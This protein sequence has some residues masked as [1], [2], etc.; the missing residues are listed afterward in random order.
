[1]PINTQLLD[2]LFQTAGDAFF[3]AEANTG[4][5]IEANRRAEELTGY[6][7]SELI[8][9][10]QSQL[11]P[12]Q[13]VDQYRAIF[14]KHARGDLMLAASV[15]IVRKDGA[16]VPVEIQ[17]SAFEFEGRRLVFGIFRDVSDRDLL[18]RRLEQSE[19]RNRTIAEFAPISIV[20]HCN[21]R[22][23]FSNERAMRDL[24]ARTVGDLLGL[25]VLEFVHP[26][27][28]QRVN[29]RIRKMMIEKGS[30]PM[31]EERLQRLNGEYFNAEVHATA[32]EWDGMPS[33]MVAFQ[34]IDDRA[35]RRNYREA[36]LQLLQ[37]AFRHVD[38]EATLRELVRVHAERTNALAS[39]LTIKQ[40][41]GLIVRADHNAPDELIRLTEEAGVDRNASPSAFALVNETSIFVDCIEKLP[42]DER[43]RK[44]LSELSITSCWSY[45]VRDREGGSI[46]SLTV[47]LSDSRMPDD[48]ELEALEQAS[49]LTS[50]F[51]DRSDL[52]DE[53][54]RLSQVARQTRE[55]VILTDKDRKVVYVNQA[56]TDVTGYTLKDVAGKNLR[57][58]MHGPA[59]N[60]ATA[61]FMKQRLNEIRGFDCRIFNYRKTGEGFW[62]DLRIDPMFDRTGTHVGFI[63]LQTDV[64]EE[65]EA[66]ARLEK[67]LEEADEASKA[68]SEFLSIISHEIRTP[69]NSISGIVHL[70]SDRNRSE[71]Q[72]EE[73]DILKKSAERLQILVSDILDFGQMDAGRLSFQ[74]QPFSFPRLIGQLCE[75]FEPAFTH[76]P[77]QFEHYIDPAIPE[78]LSADPARIRQVYYHLLSNAQKFTAA[79]TV[80]LEIKLLNDT[81]S[82]VVIESVL[83]DTGTGMSQTVISRIFEPFFRAEST[84]TGQPNGAG[85]GLTIAKRILEYYDGDITVESRP[86]DGSTFRFRMKIEKTSESGGTLVSMPHLKNARV[87]IV[88]D[89]EAN[90]LIT[91]KFL[92]LWDIQVDQAYNGEEALHKVKNGQYDLILMDLHMP[93]MDG[94]EATRQIRTFN[95]QI[96]IVA[97]TASAQSEVQDRIKEVGMNDLIVKPFHP[98]E[99]NKKISAFLKN[100]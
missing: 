2:V 1:M 3:I 58:I 67:T 35:R 14:A 13:M 31:L 33:V 66:R 44:R 23:V 15:Q 49:Y 50:V 38:T 12:H 53:N 52:L 27:D 89:Y 45:P 85:L 51:M 34:D 72:T 78:G 82:H 90:I 4:R 83:T 79:G 11:H 95:N 96:P 98:A 37:K 39:L 100:R 8:E 84:A 74:N 63:G 41:D 16:V 43:F 10:H 6:D 24:G 87:L 19:R 75:S 7:R 47:Y 55:G 18:H 60:M 26:E 56:F 70:L 36:M 69:L 62:N 40:D 86:H 46:G 17:G 30:V 5:I 64:T 20:V 28:L 29:E 97:L 54:Y 80:R 73:L 76:T 91:R 77:V 71:D 65:M 59:T 61:Q 88:E 99:L 92:E 42:I 57:T 81:G 94:Y 9:M 48:E 21:G 93:V 25:N 32:I 68:R 22:V